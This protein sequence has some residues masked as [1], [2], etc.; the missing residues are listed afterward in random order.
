MLRKSY[1][2]LAGGLLL[3]LFILHLYG[4]EDRRVKKPA[5]EYSFSTRELKI[6][7]VPERNIFV[8]RKRFEPLARYL[9]EK[10]GVTITLVNLVTYE[11]I[12]SSFQ[13]RELDGAFLGSFTGAVVL[14][15]LGAQPVAR[16]EL[17]D[18]T[19]TY[20]GMIFTRKDS[21]IKS[22]RDMKGKT[23]VFA[24][25]GTTAGWLLP[26]HYFRDNGITDPDS[27]F[28]KTYYT[29]THEDAILDVYN[30]KAD[31]GAAKSTIYKIL[32]ENNPRLEHELTVL[33]TSPPV[34]ENSL[35]LCPDVED[36]LQRALR[37][38]LLSM[39]QDEEGKK[40]LQALGAVRFI[41]TSASDYQPVFDYA[42]QIGID[43]KTYS[44]KDD[45]AILNGD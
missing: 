30:G 14:K 5:L 2:I 45:F 8:Q 15:K 27:W 9:T 32:A 36:A 38:I 13:E 41:A 33:A 35:F 4:C 29:G 6:G 34:P 10:T 19:S 37:E 11:H 39:H 12:I 42:E 23:F 18:G 44:S 31:A 21:G 7:I 40:A 26:L 1:K 28:A 3:S 16:P 17:A 22:A 24:D 43:L 20:Q 25:R